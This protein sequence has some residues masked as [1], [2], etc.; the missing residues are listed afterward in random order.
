MT[1][2]I[3]DLENQSKPNVDLCEEC[4]EDSALFNAILYGKSKRLCENCANTCGA[5]ILKKPDTKQIEESIKP[6]TNK[7][8]KRISGI[9]PKKTERIIKEMSLEDMRQKAKE[10][11]EKRE[12]EKQ[13]QEELK[14]EEKEQKEKQKNILYGK[15]DILDEKEFL[16]YLENEM[17]EIKE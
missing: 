1:T 14:Q 7:S 15:S 8:L 6:S 5:I 17:A 16:D 3:E 12:K 9:E 10:L 2:E 4:Y 13:K 11:K